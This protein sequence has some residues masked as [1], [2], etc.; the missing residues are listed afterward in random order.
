MTTALLLV[1]AQRGMLEAPRPVPAHVEVRRALESLL[2]RAREAGVFVV[3][4]QND[5]PLGDP[6]EPHTSGWDLAF[7][8][9]SSELVFRKTVPDAFSNA[10]LGASLDA[11]Q[12]DQVVV[13]G[14]QSNYCVSATCRGA[15]HHG[16]KVILASGAHATYDEGESAETISAR[17][18][19][20]LGRDG[21][22]IIPADEIG[23]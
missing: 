7:P 10:G 21:V 4:V 2:A 16:L 5:G 8:V 19:E 1:D 3:F 14:M 13:A 17:V 6:D 20:E 12:V 11:G 9:A 18:E 15:L 22:R 23:F